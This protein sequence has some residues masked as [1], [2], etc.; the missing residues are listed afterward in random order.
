MLLLDPLQQLMMVV[1]DLK[2]IWDLTKIIDLV[3]HGASVIKAK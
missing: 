3:Q 1:S 2:S